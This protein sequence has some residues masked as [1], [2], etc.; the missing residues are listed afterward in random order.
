ML[1]SLLTLI[2]LLVKGILLLHRECLVFEWV[3][4][5]LGA[6][7][8]CTSCFIALDVVLVQ[9]LAATHDQRLLGWLSSLLLF[10]PRLG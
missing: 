8:I 3:G 7:S 6:S 9:D 4:S 10:A 5:Q 1:L 2:L